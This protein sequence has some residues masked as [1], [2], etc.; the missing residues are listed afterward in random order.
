VLS[1]FENMKLAWCE[2]IAAKFA[3]WD[4]LPHCLFAMYPPD[5]ESRW[6]AARSLDKW[7]QAVAAGQASQCHRVTYRLLDPESGYEFRRLIEKLAAEGVMEP[8]LEV[9][10]QE[11]NLVATTEQR[12]AAAKR[13]VLRAFRVLPRCLDFHV[14]LGCLLRLRLGRG[15][16]LDPLALAGSG[17]AACFRPRPPG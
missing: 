1:E 13:G 17:V 15:V 10:L 8:A 11:M 9:E 14:P 7:Q 2:E 4:E 16:M 6:F 12:R 3:Y 5:A